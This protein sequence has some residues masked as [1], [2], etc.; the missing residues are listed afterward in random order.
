MN[1]EAMIKQAIQ[2][3]AIQA[4]ITGELDIEELENTMINLFK[5]LNNE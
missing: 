3:W 4:S 2:E 5:E 1:E